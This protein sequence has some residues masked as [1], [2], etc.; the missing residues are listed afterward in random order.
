MTLNFKKVRGKLHM[1]MASKLIAAI[2]SIIAILLVSGVISILEFR[3]MSNYVSDRISDNIACMNMS[4]DLAV[5]LDEYNLKILSSVGKADSIKISGINPADYLGVTDSLVWQMVEKR[6]P[7]ADSLVAAYSRYK[8]C[9]FQLDD[10]IVS[11]FVDTR[12]WF[13]TVLQPEY[14]YMRMW[15]DKVN[16]GIHDALRD[17]SVSFDE[18]FYRSIMPG[19]VS[20][21]VGILLVILLLF[22]ILV[23]YVR[24]LD[25]MLRA[26]DSFRR[27]SHPYNVVFEGD[28]QLQELNGNISEMAAEISIV[29][30]KLRERER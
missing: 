2:S 6:L 17:N 27:Y 18:S 21:A 13:F 4:S 30:K 1:G 26:L 9:S 11:D 28:D 3:R 23:Y 10:V 14:N 7:Y 8:A 12:D 20:V 16:L 25:K 19:V 29:K 22:F 24:P 15:Q 5:A